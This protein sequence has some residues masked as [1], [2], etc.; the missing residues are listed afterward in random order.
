M[1]A[2][3]WRSLTACD[4]ENMKDIALEQIKNRKNTHTC[5]RTHIIDINHKS[6][7]TIESTRAIHTV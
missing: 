3:Y 2:D 1:N 7:Q 4:M 5:T 6:G